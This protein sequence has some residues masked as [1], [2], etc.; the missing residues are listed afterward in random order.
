[1]SE[2][3]EYFNVCGRVHENKII[4]FDRDRFEVEEILKNEMKEMRCIFF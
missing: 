4:I 2:F 3:R 1:M